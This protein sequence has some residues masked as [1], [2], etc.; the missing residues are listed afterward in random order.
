MQMISSSVPLARFG[1]PEEIADIAVFICS[2]AAHSLQE[3]V[4]RPM[5]DKLEV[6]EEKNPVQTLLT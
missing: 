6:S 3:R 4:L 5:A 1:T 2:D